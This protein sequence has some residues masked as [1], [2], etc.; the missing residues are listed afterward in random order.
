[1]APTAINREDKGKKTPQ[2]KV[3]SQLG[4]N[5]NKVTANAIPSTIQ[6]QSPGKIIEASSLKKQRLLTTTGKG[7]KTNGVRDR[8]AELVTEGNQEASTPK[9]GSY[10]PSTCGWAESPTAMQVDD[11]APVTQ[12]EE[13]EEEENE[14]NSVNGDLSMTTESPL[15][16]TRLKC[17]FDKLILDGVRIAITGSFPQPEEDDL[18][19]LG[20]AYDL[21][22]GKNYIRRLVT[23]HGAR[24]NDS[25]YSETDFLLVGKRPVKAMLER[26]TVKGVRQISQKTF[27]EIIHGK[28]S[29]AEALK[30]PDPANNR[31]N[32]DLEPPA[33]QRNVRMPEQTEDEDPN[34]VA[35]TKLRPRKRK[36]LS[37]T[38]KKVN[39]VP[40]TEI[41][42]PRGVIDISRIP[43]KK[44]P[45]HVS[46]IQVTLRVPSGTVKDLVMDLLFSGLDTV[47]AEDKTVC[48]VHPTTPEQYAKK[49]QDMPEKFQK[50]HEEWAKFDQPIARFKND[51]KVGRKRTYNLS[52]WL[53]SEKP[54]KDILSACE[55]E[56]EE[57][58]EN[59]GS[60]KFSYKRMQSLQTSRN[61]MLIGVPTDLDAEALQVCLKTKMEEAR[62]KMVERNQFK[63][64]SITKV[65]NFVLEKDFIKNTPYTERSEEDD[66]PFWAKMPFHLEYVSTDE[67]HLDQILAY[68]YRAKRFQGI[69][70]EAAFYYKNPGP[71]ASAGE[72]NVL[73]GI[74]MRHIAMVRSIGRVYI[75]GITHPDRAFPLT[76]YDEEEPTEVDFGVSRSVREI[77]MEK[78]I[79][80]SKIWILLAQTTDGR[81]A[82]YYRFG[83]GNEDHKNS[84]LEWSAS[85][86]AHIR[87]HLLGRGFD[88]TGINDLIKGS[89]DIQAVKDAA[90]A[91]VGEDGRVKSLRQAEAEQILS[92]HDKTQ[93]WVNL[94]LG[95]TKKQLE[96]YERAQVAQAKTGSGHKGE[97]NFED[98]HSIDP[99]AG[100]PDDGTALTK[101]ANQSLGNMAYDIIMDDD[102]ESDDLATNLYEDEGENGMDLD[103]DQVH[104][105]N[106]R[107]HRQSTDTEDGTGTSSKESRT[108]DTRKSESNEETSQ[109]A[110]SGGSEN[111]Q[112]MTVSLAKS[113]LK[114]KKITFN[115][116]REVGRMETAPPAQ[117][118]K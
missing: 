94:E 52:I 33:I 26:A 9:H 29:V 111:A 34:D 90:Q 11:T 43:K 57:E 80:G 91:V 21:Y 62:L 71:E 74:L 7:G 97:Y 14:T 30:A 18:S 78:K 45:K 99:A 50:I 55:L 65:P 72:R 92:N 81:W 103:I 41:I 95:M 96:E 38:P 47:R 53:G 49:R 13:R 117:A 32:H 73:A 109:A 67:D 79:H 93:S 110:N 98:T 44:A 58:R 69:F 106:G 66:I 108:T 35:F 25:V 68:M 42:R 24:Y 6:K 51:I 20:P 112:A 19:E 105:D 75:K 8:P 23:S 16:K 101:A 83:I 114:P 60:V 54:T 4:F 15:S 31:E 12:G 48:F 37:V 104:Q 22:T 61:L 118:Q 46:V 3:Q 36:D 27:E 59:G 10:L 77:M 1:M 88:N 40:G 87:F 107:L 115:Q 84:A 64:G 102:S 116:G 89:F 85:L 82:G 17:K 63:Y 70:G 39:L 86:S 56:W 76:R 28:T 2:Q 100:K 5:S 113:S